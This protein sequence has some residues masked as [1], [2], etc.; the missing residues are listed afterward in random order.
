MA[1]IDLERRAE[2]GREKRARTRAAILDA[3]RACY[4][5]PDAPSV[6]IESVMQQAGLAK[7][8][9]YLHFTDLPSLEA[10]LGDAL[11]AELAERHEPARQAV[12]EPLAR[13]ATAVTIFLRD[14][15]EAPARARLVAHAIVALPDVGEAVQIRLKDDLAGAKERGQ[16]AVGSVELASRIVIALV[17]QAAFLS[18]AGKLESSAVP[19][20]VRAILR[21]LG[22]TPD[23]AAKRAADAARNA[24]M[25]AQQEAQ[26]Q[27]RRQ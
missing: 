8:T 26:P 18:G 9:F 17:Q 6:T 22:C 13:L 23:G 10:A 15:A 24:D 3:A 27:S 5:D 2:I 11:I 4:A 7:G 20:L 14:I 1:R 21:A 16:I 25:F 12:T 19:D